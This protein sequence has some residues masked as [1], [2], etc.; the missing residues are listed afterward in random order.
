MP[1]AG[2]SELAGQAAVPRTELSVES[3]GPDRWPEIRATWAALA[4]ASPHTSF[5]LTAEWLDCWLEQFGQGAN[6]EFLSFRAGAETVGIC[7]LHTKTVRR[8][9]LPL[10]RIYLNATGEGEGNACMEFN[11]L[12]CLAGWELP[13]A[14]RLAAHLRC[15]K[16]DELALN[17][18]AEG[19]SLQ[20]LLQAFAG[21]KLIRAPRPSYYVD[22]AAIRASGTSYE[23]SLGRKT[24][25]NLRRYYRECAKSGEL[26]TRAAGSV[27]EALQ[28]LDELRV[29][30]QAH[31]QAKGQPGAFAS[32][33][34]T[35]FHRALI[36][37]TFPLGQSQVVRVSAGDVIGLEYLFV[38]RRKVYY[39][40]AGVRHDPNQELSPGIVTSACAVNYCL[41]AGL[42][43]F[44]FLASTSLYKKLLSTG[45]RSL[46]WAVLQQDNWKTRSLASL[47]SLKQRLSR[48]P[49]PPESGN[50]VPDESE[51]EGPSAAP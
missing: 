1:N 18:F 5:F 9:F 24:R 27:E 21:Y 8:H 31:W 29:L 45:S 47:K 22:L 15:R 6:L 39:Y 10:S 12:L 40:Q 30:H 23:D 42:K 20:A 7:L 41:A 4:E 25:K 28:L 35:A 38:Y 33:R 11:N 16:W 51:A 26:T 14:I 32:Q 34:F 46:D 49:R 50:P 43:E 17:G 36:R 37:R 44:D 13:V 19:P 3:C 48:A 2:L